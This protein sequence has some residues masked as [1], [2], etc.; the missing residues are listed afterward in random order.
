MK[1]LEIKHV[2]D[3][4][5]GS[6]IKE[7]LFSTKITIDTI[8]L[9][10]KNGSLQYFPDFALPFYK[11]R[12]PDLY[13]LKGIEGNNYVQIHIKDP[14]KFSIDKFMGLTLRGV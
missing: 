5:D 3:C 7:L 2:E 10:A 4:F 9:W 12:V 8:N 1:L 14:V 6:I 11:I 13:D